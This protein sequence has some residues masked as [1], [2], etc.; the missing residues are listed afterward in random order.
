M[1]KNSVK[2]YKDKIFCKISKID[3]SEKSSQKSRKKM[4]ILRE[5]KVN[6]WLLKRD[7]I[8]WND[9]IKIKFR[10]KDI[11]SEKTL[12]IEIHKSVFLSQKKLY[13]R[14]LKQNKKNR[15]P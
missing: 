10:I 11:F 13:L 5:K 3:F 4:Y 1:L 9:Q 12:P 14:Y 6:L 15:R 8:G 2:K 7:E